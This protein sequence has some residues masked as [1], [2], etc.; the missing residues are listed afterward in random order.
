MSVVI[1]T[2]Q[3]SPVSGNGLKYL[4]RITGHNA[5]IPGGAQTIVNHPLPLL[6][7][8]GTAHRLKIP[9]VTAFTEH[10][11]RGTVHSIPARPCTPEGTSP[12]C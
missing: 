2:G 9:V 7:K 10:R 8:E 11:A 6:E 12:A 4:D 1:D 3:Q 5:P